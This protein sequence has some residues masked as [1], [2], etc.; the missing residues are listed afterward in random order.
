MTLNLFSVSFSHDFI[1]PKSEK[2][3][4]GVHIWRHQ[5]VDI[6]KVEKEGFGVQNHVL[7]SL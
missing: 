4:R 3:A 1:I 5:G 6:S 7:D 2:D